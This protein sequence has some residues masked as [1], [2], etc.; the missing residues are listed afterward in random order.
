M[1]RDLR[2]GITLSFNQLVEQALM[3]ALIGGQTEFVALLFPEVCT[4]L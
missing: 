3:W 4:F 1:G 2:E